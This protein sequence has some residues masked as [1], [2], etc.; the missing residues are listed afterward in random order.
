MRLWFI[1]MSYVLS[2][3]VLALVLP[4]LDYRYLPQAVHE[5]SV[6]SAQSF[7]AAASSGMMALTGIIFSLAFVIVQFSGAAYSPRLVSW[8]TRNP[9]LFHALGIFVATFVY[10]L[11]T[12]AWVDRGRN[13]YVPLYST[14]LVLV[15]LIASMVLLVQL[16]LQVGHLQITNV[17]R[18]VGSKGRAAVDRSFLPIDADSSNE[19]SQIAHIPMVPST[20]P[21][22]TVRYHGAPKIVA[23]VD[24]DRLVELASNADALVSLTFSVGDALSD[25]MP[26]FEVYGSKTVIPEASL[27]RALNL[28]W[29]RNANDP[30]Y[31]FRILVD[32]AIKALS[33]AVNDPTTAVQSIDQIEDL[34]S[35][36]ARR[37][38]DTGA[39]F[40]SA[41]VLRVVYPAATWEDYLALAFDEIRN[42]G[43]SQ[44]QILRRLRA[45]L[46]TLQVTSGARSDAVSE[47]LHQLD[48]TIEGSPLDTGDR[49]SARREDRQGIGVAR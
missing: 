4:R 45:A 22:Q 18:F 29:E 12:L 25:A 15:L 28:A 21:T 14:Y 6:S 42:C 9:L 40:D 44:I 1:T 34:L 41:G 37:R 11:G 16:V 8:F 26:L 27:L 23:S 5:V 48:V 47:Y 31:V 3:I 19:P 43:A 17:L 46:N 20:S 35:R 36:L 38:L 13:G 39:R 30:K 32:I 7:L 10:S 33:P 2:S 24:L 49:A